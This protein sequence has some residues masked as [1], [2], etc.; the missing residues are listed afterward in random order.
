MS[1]EH[2]G[3][4]GG[5]GGTGLTGRSS[6][7]DL[8]RAVI[9]DTARLGGSLTLFADPG[10]GESA[11]FDDAAE[12]A[13]ARSMRTLRAAGAQFEANFAFAGLNQLLVPLV[14][15]FAELDPNHESALRVALGFGEGATPSRILISAAAL[16]LLLLAARQHPLVAIIDDAQWLDDASADVL[17]FVVRR[18]A[19]TRVRMLSTVR[20]S[21]EPPRIRGDVN[22]LTI[23]SLDDS[24]TRAL[25]LARY[26]DLAEKRRRIRLRGPR[27]PARSRRATRDADVGPGTPRR[28]RFPPCCR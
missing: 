8:I 26:P 18:V 13:R 12:L 15:L 23:H 25:L 20:T 4:E 21:G 27:E 9:D 19:G 16:S 10:V 22:S 1:A 3:P 7:W 6:E 14:P 11:L 24:A 17:S 28:T 2:P 5:G